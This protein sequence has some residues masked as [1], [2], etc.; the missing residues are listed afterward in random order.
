M[1]ALLAT[2]HLLSGC[3]APPAE[4]VAPPPARTPPKLGY[5]DADIDQMRQTIKTIRYPQ[6]K[7]ATARALGLVQL[8]SPSLAI[9]EYKPNAANLNATYEQ[10]YTLTHRHALVVIE[11]HYL[12]KDGRGQVVEQSA[13]IQPASP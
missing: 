9:T 5:S 13:A 10:R 1:A 6:P 4:P 8:T 7:G 11:S 3:N 12:D 2:A